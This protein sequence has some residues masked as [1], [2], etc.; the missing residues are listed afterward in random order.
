VGFPVFWIDLIVS[1]VV[2][3]AVA[4]TSFILISVITATA[5]TQHVDADSAGWIIAFFAPLVL[6]GIAGFSITL[7]LFA[8]MLFY[9]W[10]QAT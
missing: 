1:T 2:G 7:G 9:F 5:A 4:I 6:P 3:I 8:G 10:R